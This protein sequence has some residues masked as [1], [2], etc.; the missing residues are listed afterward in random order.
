MKKPNLLSGLAEAFPA[1]W[2]DEISAEL[3]DGETLLAWV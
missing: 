1:R 3:A 2:R